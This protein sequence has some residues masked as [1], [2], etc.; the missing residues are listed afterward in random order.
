[1]KKKLHIY[2]FKAFNQEN[3]ESK[4]I[5]QAKLVTTHGLFYMVEVISTKPVEFLNQKE[6]NNA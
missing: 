2:K 1:M 6:Y 5:T 4:N 3:P